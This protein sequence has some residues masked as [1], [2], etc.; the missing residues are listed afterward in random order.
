MEDCPLFFWK[1][2]KIDTLRDKDIRKI[3]PNLQVGGSAPAPPTLPVIR[4]V[5][6]HTERIVQ[7]HNSFTVCTL[8]YR[9]GTAIGK[10]I[11][12][13]AIAIL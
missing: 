8:K 6:F 3:V 2:L 13:T 11:A 5:L 9:V 12:A 10:S 7:R 4:I 1:L